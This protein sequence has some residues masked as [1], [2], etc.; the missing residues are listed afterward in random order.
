[1]KVLLKCI[2]LV[3]T[4]PGQT[5]MSESGEGGEEGVKPIH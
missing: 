1:M 5:D 4:S 2:F 3:S